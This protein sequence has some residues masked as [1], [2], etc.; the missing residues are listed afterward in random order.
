[1][2]KPSGVRHN[3]YEILNLIGYGL[4]KYEMDLMQSLGFATKAELFRSMI[5]RGVATTT[6]TL[7]NR[8]DLFNP[9]VR[10]AKVGWWQN[11]DKYLHRKLLLDSL[12]GELDAG[13]YAALLRNYLYTHFPVSGEVKI[14]IAPI[15]KSKFRQLQETGQEA[16]LY[17]MNNYRSIVQFVDATLDNARLFGD[18]YDFQ[19]TVHNSHVL[20]EIKGVR[21]TAG[22]I[23]LTKNEYEKAVEFE[24]SFC[25]VV[26]SRLESTPR[27]SVFFDPT[28]LLALSKKTTVSEQV[29]YTAPSRRW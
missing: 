13:E 2:S 23:R 4:A 19:V 24:S 21:G 26:V 29:Y 3:N 12:F 18:G 14:R 17:F 8:Q 7:K 6:D 5:S 9:L 11:Q 16:E 15:L 20:A 1:M 28:K 22:G 27:I 10:K 25:L